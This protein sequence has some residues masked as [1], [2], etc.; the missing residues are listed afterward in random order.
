MSVCGGKVV[1]AAATGGKYVKDIT[2]SYASSKEDSQKELGDDFVILDQDFNEG[3]SGS[4]WIGYT[5]TDDPEEAIR[6][7]KVE[8]M[9]GG[10][11][12]S[13]NMRRS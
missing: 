12:P 3:K 5:T 7:I 1:K 6:D 2:I 8:L 9:S 13:Q 10:G 11:T 4:S